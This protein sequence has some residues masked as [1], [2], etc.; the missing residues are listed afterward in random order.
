MVIEYEYVL[1][2][3]DQEATNENNLLASP[4]LLST[5]EANFVNEFLAEQQSDQTYKLLSND[6]TNNNNS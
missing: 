5:G 6:T 4:V 1:V 3:V 2:K